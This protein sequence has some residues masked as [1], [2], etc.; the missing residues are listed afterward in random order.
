MLNVS[1]INFII[2]LALRFTNHGRVSAAVHDNNLAE[3]PSRLNP[4]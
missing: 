1:T 3:S 2:G 4:N